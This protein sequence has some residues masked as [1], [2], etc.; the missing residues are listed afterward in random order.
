MTDYSSERYSP[1]FPMCGRFALSFDGSNLH[2]TGGSR[3][4]T[5]PAVSGTP[6]NGRFDYSPARQ[7]V[8]GKGPIP[9]GVYWVRPDELDDNLANTYLMPGFERSWGR[10]RLSIHP[11]PTTITHSRGGFFIHGGT[12]AGS[13]GCIDLVREIDRF[14]EDLKREGLEGRRCQIHLTVQYPV[15]GDFPAPPSGS[16]AV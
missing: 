3:T 16:R 14:A 2:F 11:F 15:L 13:A 10:Y 5:Y 9:V 8:R 4:Y 7:R 6:I 1:S 12:V